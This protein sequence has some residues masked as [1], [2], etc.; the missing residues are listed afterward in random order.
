MEIVLTHD[1]A[2]FDAVASMLGVWK[3]NPQAVPIL[4]KKQHASVTEFLTLYKN[5]LPFVAWDDFKDGEGVTH[6]TLTDTQTRPEVRHVAN[7]T[8]MT[9]IEHHPLE[10]DD[11]PA[12]VTWQGENIGAATT[13]LV[14][15][16]QAQKIKLTSLEATLMALGI[17]ADT[18][19][20]TYGGTTARDVRAA[21]W[22]L[23]HG[24]VLDTIQRF[25]S[26]PLNPEQQK[27]FETLLDQTETRDI[28]GYDV[29]VCRA[30]SDKNI[31]G[32][33][34]VT[35]RLRD[36]LDVDAVFVLVKMPNHVQLVCR[37][38]EDAIHV[39][40]LAQF[41]GGGGHPRA[42]AATIRDKSLTDASTSVWQYLHEQIQPAVRVADLMSHGV[43]TVNAEEAITDI[44]PQLRRIGHEGFPVIDDAGRVV[45]LLTL[46][47]ADKALEHGLK[48]ATVRDVMLA[49]DVT[50][51]PDDSVATLEETMVESDWGQ[52]P[53]VDH[54]QQLIGIVTRTDL[55]KHWAQV[56]PSKATEPP[57]LAPETVYDILGDDNAQFIEQIAA[58]AQAEGIAIYIVGGVVRD[59]LLQRPNYDIDFVLE[60]DA[61]AFAEQ[62]NQRYGGKIHSHAPFGTAKWHINAEAANALGLDFDALPEHID[63]TTARSELYEHPTALPTVYNSGIKLDLRRRDF[64]VNSLAVQLS[65]QDNIWRILDFYGGMNDLDA[66]LIRVLHSLSFVDDPTRIIRAVR[67][68]ERLQFSIETRTAELIDGALSMLGRI[69]GE[70][71]RNELTLLMKERHPARGWLKLE[72]LGVLR[73]IHPDFT[74]TPVIRDAFDTVQRNDYPDWTN[75]TLSLMWHIV[76]AHVD[77]TKVEAVGTRLLFAKPQIQSMQM[78][79]QRLQQPEVLADETAKPSTISATLS[80]ISEIGLTALWIL[81]HNPMIRERI[82]QYHDTWRTMKPT[83][84]GNTLK[85]MGLKPSPK[86]RVILERLRDAWLDDEIISA[87]EEKRY[88]DQ[89]ITELDA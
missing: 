19:M 31:H 68:G 44:I 73:G 76:M 10:D 67:F 87:D 81:T 47:D 25:L 88:L 21:A 30:E 35:S 56:H 59:L 71:L 75:D 84:D 3:L 58:I 33:N 69:T 15:R 66:R 36:I 85:Q 6:I 37:S 70:R 16:I 60:G 5:G 27:L 48:R 65:P 50:L 46:R 79:A 24:A 80:D 12:H 11:I 61:I 49:G 29:A 41:F 22:L 53:I 89:L 52:I 43:T 4:P 39:G 72:A 18:G 62:L 55:I 83:V 54:N 45:G 63:F 40:N 51:T 74:V 1:N 86:F 28:Q 17:Y 9:I 7:D 26:D 42:S 82:Q 20:M 78:T 38:R 2:D 34:S 64:T 57:T 23:E 8:P 77:D 13:I 14:E 32:V